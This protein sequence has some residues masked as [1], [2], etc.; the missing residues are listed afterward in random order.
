[1]VL[2]VAISAILA[3][4]L[5][6]DVKAAEPDLGTILTDLGFTNTVETSIQTFPA[7]TYEITLYAEYAGYRDQN[8]LSWYKLGTSSFNMIFSGSE[9]VPLGDPMGLVTPPLT[10]SFNRASQFGLSLLSPDGRWCTEISI[11]PDGKKHA[12]VYQSLDD[13][14]LFFIGFENLKLGGDF[15]YNDMVFSLKHV[16]PVGGVWVPINKFDLLAPWVS[17]V[18]ATGS[19]AAISLYIKLKRRKIKLNHK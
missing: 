3:F 17:A 19:C 15:D 14:N 11:N 4:P 2:L 10:K 5:V 1:M 9:G 13:P 12:K 6:M 18:S 16:I 8:T 7:G